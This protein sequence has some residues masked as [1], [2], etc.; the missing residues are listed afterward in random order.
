MPFK[1]IFSL[2]TL[3]QKLVSTSA[4][5][6]SSSTLKMAGIRNLRTQTATPMSKRGKKH[7]VMSVELWK[8]NT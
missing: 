2:D 5:L 1:I 4:L 8:K 6:E 7:L 3:S